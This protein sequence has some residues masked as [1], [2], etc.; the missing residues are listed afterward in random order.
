MALA[1]GGPFRYGLAASWSFVNRLCAPKI[2]TS[3]A[4]EKYLLKRIGRQMAYRRRFGS[5]PNA[6]TEPHPP[7]LPQRD[8]ARLC[9]KSFCPRKSSGKRAC[10]KVPAGG[11]NW[12]KK[13][14]R[15]AG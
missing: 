14:G 10:F 12:C 11:G 13:S 9:E 5:G 2:E 8:Y 1:I 15:L 6:L 3:G 7:Q 4:S